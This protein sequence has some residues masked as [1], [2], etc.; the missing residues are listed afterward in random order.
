MGTQSFRSGDFEQLISWNLNSFPYN[1]GLATHTFK[2]LASN[3]ALML[4][5][6]M[7][8]LKKRI[9]LWSAEVAWVDS[10]NTALRTVFVNPKAK[11]GSRAKCQSGLETSEQSAEPESALV[12]PGFCGRADGFLGSLCVV[13]LR[14][15]AL[16]KATG[17]ALF[18]GEVDKLLGKS[19]QAPRP[20]GVLPRR[21]SL[22]ASLY[23]QS[24]LVKDQPC[25]PLV[26]WASE[27]LD[28]SPGGAELTWASLSC[29]LASPA[30]QPQHRSPSP[31][32]HAP[33]SWCC[34]IE[35][36]ACCLEQELEPP[37]EAA[38]TAGGAFR[39][40]QGLSAE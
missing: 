34:K 28:S 3:T 19:K 29:F 36:Q 33:R 9:D 35:A 23:T 22:A 10:E 30:G 24:P 8:T 16:L 18:A 38:P 37:T 20:H 26:T 5:V 11:V 40:S 27:D 2:A 31:E 25:W 21:S 17:K 7:L 1:W 4:T 15:T 14:L 13:T 39:A 32:G 12:R 6:Y